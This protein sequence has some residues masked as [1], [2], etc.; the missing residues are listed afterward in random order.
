MALTIGN[1]EL[2][3]DDGEEFVP[4]LNIDIEDARLDEEHVRRSM[5]KPKKKVVKKRGQNVND[6]FAELQATNA[7]QTQA[8]MERSMFG[9][10]KTK[11]KRKKKKKTMKNAALLAL[12]RNKRKSGN[13]SEIVTCSKRNKKLKQT[14]NNYNLV[15]VSSENRSFWASKTRRQELLA[16]ALALQGSESGTVKISKT[17]NY[18]G[19]ETVIQKTVDA[20]SEA[21]KKTQENASRLRSK[22]DHLDYLITKMHGPKSIS[23]VEK[24]SYDWDN[25][26]ESNKLEE[27]LVNAT[28]DG[29]LDKKD[30]LNR[31]DARRFEQERAERD[32][33]RSKRSK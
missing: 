11:K 9:K 20:D 10:T 12:T 8:I 30:F 6:I 1:I 31:V 4:D 19:K 2:G 33:Q 26:K 21:A 32:I 16:K 3:E 29:Y 23:T 27:E 5:P 22:E 17:V 18:A 25:F 15:N 13:I 7:A 28:K 24:S 14:K